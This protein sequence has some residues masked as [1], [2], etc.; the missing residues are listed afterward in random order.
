MSVF[1]VNTDGPSGKKKTHTHKKRRLKTGAGFSA[2]N[3]GK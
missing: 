2:K 1:E 3:K